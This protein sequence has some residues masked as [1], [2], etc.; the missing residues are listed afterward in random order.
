MPVRPQ[1]R[2]PTHPDLNITSAP[3]QVQRRR[4]LRQLRHSHKSSKQDDLEFF[5]LIL[6]SHT[7]FTSLNPIMKAYLATFMLNLQEQS[8]IYPLQPYLHDSFF[9]KQ[10]ANCQ[11]LFHLS[12]FTAIKM[13]FEEATRKTYNLNQTVID[14]Y[15]DFVAP[16]TSR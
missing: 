6:E 11:Q 10:L 8:S 5:N 16:N 3:E 14:N 1:L 4:Q 13:S 9:L 15:Y 7:K 12:P 2:Q